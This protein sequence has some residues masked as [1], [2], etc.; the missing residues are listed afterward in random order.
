MDSMGM[1]AALQLML[2]TRSRLPAA[3]AAQSIHV[4]RIKMPT[5]KSV[6]LLRVRSCVAAEP[7]VADLV[8]DGAGLQQISPGCTPA[9][10][11]RQ[12]TGL[13][14]QA[15][16]PEVTRKQ[17]VPGPLPAAVRLWPACSTSRPR[18]RALNL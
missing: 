5:S 3:A 4:A 14:A 10:R 8:R 11:L 9:T 1:L 16:V 17:A 12:L 6:R 13:F 18:W 2:R 15:E 7:V